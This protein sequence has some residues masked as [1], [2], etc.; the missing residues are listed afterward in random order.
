MERRLYECER[1]GRK[2]AIRSKGLCGI[3]RS[4]ELPQKKRKELHSLSA[5]N[6][7]A[8]N[9]D[10]ELSGFFR[11]MIEELNERRTSMTGYPIPYPTVCNI[12]HILPKRWYKSV[13]KTRDN[14]IFLHEDEHTVFD[15]MIDRM[16]FDKLE[17]EFPFIWKYAV[18]KVLDMYE[19][20]LIKEKGRLLIN[21]IDV[22]NGKEKNKEG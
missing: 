6:K 13:A 22:Y 11:L 16:E 14:I 21:I 9:K 18:S 17:K 20:G 15:L 1:C 8:A 7:R 3:C 2:V 5:N 19:R 10:P 12:C 4:K